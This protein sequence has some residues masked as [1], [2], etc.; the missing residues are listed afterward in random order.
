M[1]SDKTEVLHIRSQ[2]RKSLPLPDF[3]VDDILLETSESAKNLG[4]ILDT[5]LNMKPHIKKVCKSASYGIHKIGKIR[6]YLDKP[7][8]ERLIH[9][10]VTS[11]LDYCNSLLV[12]L[13][14]SHLVPLQRIQNFAARLVTRSRSFEHITPILRHLHWLPI[15]QRIQFKILLF[16]FKI[17]NGQCPTYLSKLV[18][19]KVPSSRLRASTSSHLQLMPGPRVKTRYGDRAFSVA[20]PKLWNSLPPHIQGA[21]SLHTFKTMLKTHLFKSL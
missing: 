12:N 20:A 7:A 14:P 5:A 16:A 15:T 4:V 21:P 9:A 6:K 10:F 2:F 17:R 18:K 3:V 19:P 11:H 8:T 1:N 13:P